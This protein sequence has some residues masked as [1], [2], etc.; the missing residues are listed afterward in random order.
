[1]RRSKKLAGLGLALVIGVGGM[2]AAYAADAV[3]ERAQEAKAVSAP[4]DAQ[5]RQQSGDCAESPE[6]APSAAVDAPVAA[7]GA[8][9]VANAGEVPQ[10]RASTQESTW[11]G[12]RVAAKEP[13]REQAFT[14][15]AAQ[16]QSGR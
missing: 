7:Q 2:G 3:Q 5:V 14:G 13:V 8:A 6:A 9:E 16:S 15:E 11:A 10:V 4:A 12:A 1:M